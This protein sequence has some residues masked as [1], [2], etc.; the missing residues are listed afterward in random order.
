MTV[1]VLPSETSFQRLGIT[2]SR[3]AIGKAVARNRAKRLVR[4]TFR[5]SQPALRELGREYD[6]VINARRSLLDASFDELLKEFAQIIGRVSREEG[7]AA[8]A[9]K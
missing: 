7:S 9:E 4:E 1:F 8:T 6:W 5:L 3:K 2:A